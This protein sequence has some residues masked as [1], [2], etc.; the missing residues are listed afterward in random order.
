MGLRGRF[1]ERGTRESGDGAGRQTGPDVIV[2][3]GPSG[4]IL[5]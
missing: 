1:L 2:T 3:G 5:H 4:V